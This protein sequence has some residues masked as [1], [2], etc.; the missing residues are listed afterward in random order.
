MFQR[1]L[2]DFTFFVPA[3]GYDVQ[4]DSRI[5]NSFFL[6]NWFRSTTVDHVAFW[7]NETF[8]IRVVGFCKN[9]ADGLKGTGARF[10]P[11]RS[12]I[13]KLTW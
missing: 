12:K 5:S 2:K 6:S 13:P 10:C 1:V 8:G 11:S 4:L 9:Q 3:W 7:S